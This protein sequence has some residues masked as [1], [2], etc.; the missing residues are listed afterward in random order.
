MSRSTVRGLPFR[1]LLVLGSALL[2]GMIA[3]LWP[4]S[5][6]AHESR[7]VGDGYDFVVGFTEEPAVAGEMNGVLLEVSRDGEPVEGINDSLEAQI[8]FGDQTKDVVLVPAFD[9]P[10]TYTSAF[11]PTVEGDYTFRFFGQIDSVDIDETFTSSP[12]GFDSVQPRGAYEFPT[13]EDASTTQ[14][15]AMPALIGAFVLGVGGLGLYLR[16]R[17]A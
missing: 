4:L 7:T 3:L 6:A 8:I 12:E 10:G 14:V 11:I 17:Q 5:T 1:G 2:V 13:A 9:Q 16:R 15:A